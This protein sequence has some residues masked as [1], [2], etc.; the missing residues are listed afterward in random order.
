MGFIE[1]FSIQDVKGKLAGFWDCCS[2]ALFSFT[3]TELLAI[4]AWETEYPRYTLPKAVRRV[5][6]RVI[7]YYL[8]AIFILGL[9]VSP[10]DPLLSLPLS[11]TITQADPTPP[12]YPGVF[13]I[14]VKRAG[15][16]VLPHIINAVMVIATLSVATA[17]IYI[18]V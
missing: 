16:P 4:T 17:D 9:T 12:I 13:I 8:S 6:G 11:P 1:A 2:L 14:M 3:G 10:S 15:I 18:T 5:S 7:L